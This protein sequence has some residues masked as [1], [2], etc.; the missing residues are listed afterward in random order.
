MGGDLCRKPLPFFEGF[1]GAIARVLPSWKHDEEPPRAGSPP[2]F[3]WP[4]GPGV[5]I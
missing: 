1:H 5:Y 4:L 3:K 2:T